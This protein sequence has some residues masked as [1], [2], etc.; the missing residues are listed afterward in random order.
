MSAGLRNLM[1]AGAVAAI[2]SSLAVESAQAQAQPDLERQLSEL[3][4]A[5]EGRDVA[6]DVRRRAGIA[7]VPSGFGLSGNTFSLSLSAS[8]GP[9]GPPRAA[10]GNRTNASSALAF[11]FGNAET[12]GVEVGV[13]NTST[14]DFGGSG[15][16]SVGVNRQFSYDGGIGS[17]SATASNL[18]GWGEAE[19]NEVTGTVAASFVFSLNDRP[20]MATIGATSGGG[21]AGTRNE[22]PGIIAG[23]GI[24]V[25]RDWSVSAGVVGESPVVGVSYFPAALEGASVNASLRDFDRGNDA[26]IGLDIGYAFN[27]FGQ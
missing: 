2:A 15:Y 22:G 5:L 4:A 23:F 27:L 20:A 6:V 10:A 25:A 24:G 16:F 9:E 8:Y 7:A 18:G 21:A 11:G 12:L 3:E 1:A 17:V 14:R 13:V 19:D 26:V